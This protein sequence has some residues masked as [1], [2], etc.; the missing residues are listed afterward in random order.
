MAEGDECAQWT[1]RRCE[2]DGGKGIPEKGSSE[3]NEAQG[4]TEGGKKMYK[5]AAGTVV[6]GR[7]NVVM[8]KRIR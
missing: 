7:Q 1:I 6:G 5:R 3:I 8:R 2:S 4:Q